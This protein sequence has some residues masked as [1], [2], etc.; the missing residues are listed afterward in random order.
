M[1]RPIQR[2]RLIQPPVTIFVERLII[3]RDFCHSFRIFHWLLTNVFAE[4][5]DNL[6]LQD[7]DHPASFRGLSSKALSCLKCGKQCL[8]HQVFR[9]RLVSHTEQRTAKQIIAV[10]LHPFFR[11]R[12]SS[13]HPRVPPPTYPCKRCRGWYRN[14][15]SPSN[16]P[17]SGRHAASRKIVARPS[18]FLPRLLLNAA[19]R[20]KMSWARGSRGRGPAHFPEIPCGF[21]VT[22]RDL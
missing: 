19:G 1:I 18:E 5:V 8:L 4:S 3:S 16:R 17:V 13:A 11:I 21:S 20:G 22:F 7:S 6:M 10:F 15:F 2:R 12:E 14:A 9:D